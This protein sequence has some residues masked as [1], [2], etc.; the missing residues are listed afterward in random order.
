[1]TILGRR[2]Q[3]IPSVPGHSKPSTIKVL[4]GSIQIS[5]I[6]SVYTG[7]T[8]SIMRQMSYSLVRLGVYEHLK[9][10]ITARSLASGKKPETWRL[11]TAAGLAGGLGGIAGNPAGKPAWIHLLPDMADLATFFSRYSPRTYDE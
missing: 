10:D 2:M 11:L 7:I 4:R 8:A 6:R 5:G 9:A 3:M 1:M